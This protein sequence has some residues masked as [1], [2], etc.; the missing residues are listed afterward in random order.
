MH[1]SH[2]GY[3]CDVVFDLYANNENIA[4]ILLGKKDTAYE[5]EVIAYASTNIEHKTA[6]NVVGIKTWNENK[7]IVESLV[8][9]NVIKEDLLY[10]LPSGFVQV[11]YY[12]L[13]D[14][15]LI[16]VNEVREDIKNRSRVKHETTKN[17]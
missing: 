2:K 17:N 3:E 15:A 6:D 16:E 4:I 1:V 7:G 8:K 5:Y 9:G 12:E 11:E 10:T 14:E 13:T